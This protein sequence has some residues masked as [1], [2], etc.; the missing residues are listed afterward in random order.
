MEMQRPIT[1][2]LG[3]IAGQVRLLADLMLAGPDLQE[4]ESG[5]FALVL[6]DLAVRLEGMAGKTEQCSECPLQPQ[7]EERS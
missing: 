2:Q 3:L 4:V 1:D 5:A 6:Q 7:R